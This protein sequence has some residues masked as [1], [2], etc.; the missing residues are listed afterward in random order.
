MPRVSIQVKALSCWPLFLAAAGH[1]FAQAVP[2]PLPASDEQYR[3]FIEQEQ[4][5]RG[6]TSPA[7]IEPLTA[8][9]QH[10]L[11]QQDYEPAIEHLAR[12]RQ[13]L[14]VNRGFG[15]LEE[16]PLLTQLV[17]AEEARGNLVA[18]WELEETLLE[19][20]EAH[21]GKI[22][23]VS[24]FRGVAQKRL[25]VRRRYLDGEQP[26]EVVLGCYYGR[27]D[28]ISA[29]RF[30]GAVIGT[31]PEA[32]GNCS[33]G[34]RDTVN[35]ALLLEA[36]AYQLLA[37]DALLK[38]DRYTSDELWEVLM[39]TLRTSYSLQRRLPLFS[40][41]ALGQ[42]MTRLLAHES[43]AAGAEVRRAHILIQ[44]ADTNVVRTRQADRYVGYAD[45]LEQYQQAYEIMRNENVGQAGLDAVFAPALPVALPA[46]YTNPLAEVPEAD[47]DGYIDVSF[48]I[49]NRGRSKRIAT[50]ATSGNVTRSDKRALVQLI[51]QTSFRPRMA[52]GQVVE[53]TPVTVR[54]YLGVEPE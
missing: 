20:A 50:F 24:I 16:L 15:T 14:R 29:I 42:M 41:P 8:L 10:Y 39:E 1:A 44:L 38:N 5:A 51:D 23:T 6:L 49:T 47:A 12:A 11:E 27:D 17:T 22:E 3:A 34:E 45:V 46:F 31:P 18:A 13:V 43:S 2:E 54:Y 52:E 32:R 36:R 21:A 33:A 26:P 28:H 40:D 53:S 4:D 35:V 48:E 7:L 9:A 37:L 19:Q 25:Q 30:R